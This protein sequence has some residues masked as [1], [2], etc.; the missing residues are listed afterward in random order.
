MEVCTSSPNW[1][2]QVTARRERGGSVRQGGGCSWNIQVALCC[3]FS[4]QFFLSQ[5]PRQVLHSLFQPVSGV[6]WLYAWEKRKC[7]WKIPDKFPGKVWAQ[8]T[9][10]RHCGGSGTCCWCFLV[11]EEEPELLCYLWFYYNQHNVE[12]ALQDSERRRKGNLKTVC[13]RNPGKRQWFQKYL[14]EKWEYKDTFINMAW[15]TGC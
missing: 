9:R 4:L 15:K 3:V 8:V 13:L 7:K 5:I 14:T 12:I 1:H 11:Q 10:E 2:R 6:L